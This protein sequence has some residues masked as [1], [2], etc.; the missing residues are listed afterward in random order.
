MSA[1]SSTLQDKL[2][3][4]ELIARHCPWTRG[5]SGTSEAVSAVL[6]VPAGP[7]FTLPRPLTVFVSM[8]FSLNIF[9]LGANCI[10]KMRAWF[11]F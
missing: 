4:R 1:A 10:L 3:A 11:E 9:H 5:P 6:C 2:H 7:C 8:I